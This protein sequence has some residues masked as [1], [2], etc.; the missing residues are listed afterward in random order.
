[1]SSP[2]PEGVRLNKF[3]ASCGVGSRRACDALV[4]EGQVLVNGEIE[5]NPAYRVQPE[6]S[7]RAEGKTLTEKRL[8]TLV[9]HKPAGLVCSRFDEEGKPTVYSLLPGRFHHLAHV[10]RL[11]LD[12]E[13]LLLMSNDG[14]LTQALTHPSHKIPKIYHVTLVSAFDNNILDQLKNGVYS[15]NLGF[16]LRAD[17]VKR[18][19]SR[20][21]EIILTSG[22]KRQIREMIMGVGHRVNR[23]IRYEVGPLHL[24][25]LPVGRWRVLEP[26]ERQALVQA[27]QKGR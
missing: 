15:Q 16:K 27:S 20:R 23:L 3:L 18:L 26:S 12:S 6:D 11:D 17:S 14:E 10:G 7:V 24:G 8:Q 9:V 22:K 19:S 5:L 21:I 25:D 1:M 4:Q 13:G 2:A